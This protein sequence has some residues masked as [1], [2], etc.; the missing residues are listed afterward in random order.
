MAAPAPSPSGEL[1]AALLAPS[2]E[3]SGVAAGG[4]VVVSGA[5]PPAANQIPESIVAT[6]A[7]VVGV[8]FVLL[9]VLI[10]CIIWMSLKRLRAK[11]VPE[12]AADPHERGLQSGVIKFSQA[13]ILEGTKRYN[14]LVKKE[15]FSSSYKLSRPGLPLLMARRIYLPAHPRRKSGEFGDV[16]ARMAQISSH[17]NLVS[18]W[19]ANSSAVSGTAVLLSRAHQAVRG[20]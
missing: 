6:V 19:A 9:S 20:C 5:S 18:T 3:D 4:V 8:Y 17:P 16:V 2:P 11:C 15:T 7:L 10:G 1:V 14:S 12:E 13:Q